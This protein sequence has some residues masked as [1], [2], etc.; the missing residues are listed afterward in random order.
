MIQTVRTTLM[1]EARSR[2]GA[3]VVVGTNRPWTPE[4]QQI[5]TIASR[6][7]PVRAR[8]ETIDV[9]TLVRPA[10]GGAAVA[11]MVELRG[12][13]PAFPFYGA[14]TLT[15]AGLLACAARRPR[16]PGAP[17]ATDAA[18]DRCRRPVLIG[19][20]PFTIRGVIAQ[21]P[22]RRAGGFSFGSRVLVDLQDLKGTGL[23][24]F[25]SRANY[26]LLLQVDEAGVE[27]LREAAPR[28]TSRRT[29]PARPRIAPSKTTSAKISRARR[30]T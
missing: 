7:A 16:R 22:G 29:S 10:S 2:L 14:V 13:E 15:T 11:R 17:G 21:E 23:L 8:M 24:T 5:S 3:D 18:G 20:Q 4:L 1:S 27:P 12:V 6:T 28:A 26:R 25:G 19:G 9:A 30:T